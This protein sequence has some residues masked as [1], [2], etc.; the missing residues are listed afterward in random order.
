MLSLN[1]VFSR[2]D[3]EAW[4]KRTEKLV[5]GSKHE[6]FVDIKM[7][8]LGAA[9]V[10]EDGKFVR[11][12]TRGDGFVGEDV[13]MNVRTI[14][15]VPLSLRHTKGYEK[16]LVGRTEIRGEIIMLKHD[17]EALNRE[18]E[19]AGKPVYANPRNLAA[20]TIRQLDPRLAAA[21]K[22]QFMGYDILRDDSSE[23]A[24]NMYAYEAMSQLGINR[25]KQATVYKK[26]DQVMKFVDKWE[27]ERHSLPF[28]TD[29]LVIKINDRKLYENLGV[30]GKNPRAAVA[31]KYPAEEATST[32][33]DIV[34]SIGR[35][36]AATPI[37]VIE[38]VVI[39]GTTV[40]HAS[41]H[42]SDEIERKDIRVG[43]TAVVYKAGDII[44][45]VDR[46]LIE[47]RP[48][49]SREFNMQAE[50]KRQYPE[51]KFV[52]PENEAVY[53]VVGATGS[54][55]L[56]KGLEHFA[57]KSA[58]NIDGLGEK[59]VIALVNAGLV[60]DLADIYKITKEE[61]EEID[62]FADL[63]ASNLIK[64]IENSKNPTLP[65]FIYALGIRHVG[66]Q[67]AIDLSEYFGSLEKLRGATIEEL[68]RVEGVGDIVAESI[69]A[70]FADPDNTELLSKFDELGVS[71]VFESTAKGPL[72]GQN[73]VITGTLNEMSRDEAAN[74]IRELGG[75]F[76]TS[77]AND[78][79]YLVLGDSPGN[80]KIVKATKLG[81]KQIKET[82]LIQLLDKQP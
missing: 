78:T 79:D 10:Y 20:G 54:L 70:W 28:N 77:V 34:L 11:A 62:R 36:G 61:I 48:K 40:Q 17:F 31:Y 74:K 51:L 27:I 43:D 26:I 55:L 7:D 5:P 47:L 53:R 57:S 29:G 16:F 39:A 72:H 52:R 32:I 67:T 3:V 82:E 71:P 81:T 80:S 30:V 59:N 49:S 22:L 2:E 9:L 66:V 18:Q 50:L 8:G 45:Q 64:G 14:K 23:I 21:R 76:Q 60:H 69:Y 41:L 44:P 38:P 63:S 68:M 75:K 35:T 15:N 42:N 56:E 58:L 19:A 6:F 73:F 1:D 13:T 4:I 37:A 25:N 12:I 65:R 46:V 33:I 24:T